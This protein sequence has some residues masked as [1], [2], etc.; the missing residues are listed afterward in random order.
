MNTPQYTIKDCRDKILQTLSGVYP[1]EEIRSFTLIIL[2]HLTGLPLPSILARPEKQ[3]TITNWVKINE[4]CGHLKDFTPIQYI[5]GESQFLDFT[6]KVVP[7]VLIPRPETEEL[8]DLIVKE[9]QVPGVKI[10]DV[11]TGSGVIALSLSILLDSPQINA[12]D[13]NPL[14]INLAKQ[15]CLRLGANVNIIEEDIF[16]PSIDH[17]L[18]DII[19]SNPPYVRV[20]EQTQMAPNVLN[21]EPYSALFVADSD[22]LKFYRGVLEFAETSLSPG[23]KIY[24][25]I[26]EALGL[27]MIGLA[28]KFNYKQIRLVKDINGKDR[29]MTLVKDGKNEG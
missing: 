24:F 22:P 11:G 7:G 25:E 9:N 20:S 5:L 8:V 16:H 1:P 26:N 4:I 15:N 6:F 10:L 28:E 2:N 19:V 3:V 14:A 29:I 27:E 12:S 17:P 23:G 13:I 18:Y 21:Y